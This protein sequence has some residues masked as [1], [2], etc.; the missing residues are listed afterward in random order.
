VPIYLGMNA[1][2][3]ASA[4]PASGPSLDN[5]RVLAGLIDLAIVGAGALAIA[6][7][8]GLLGGGGGEI[9]LPVVAVVT[10]W[11]LYY[12]FALE[13]GS[14]QTLGKK[15]MKIRVV[16]VDGSAAGM[17]DIAVR[18]V[19]R[20][21]DMQL[22]YLVGLVVMLLTGERRGRLGDLAAK[23]MLVSAD[24]PTIAAPPVDAVA[25]PGVALPSAGPV[26]GPPVAVAPAPAKTF[27]LPSYAPEP[28]AAAPDSA[29]PPDVASPS[30]RELAR[31]VVATTGSQGVA[32]PAREPVADAGPVVELEPSADVEPIAEAEPVPPVAEE[33]VA[34]E[35]PMGESELPEGPADEQQIVVKPVETVSAI[36]LVMGADEP[37]D[38]APG[39]ESPA[40]DSR[41]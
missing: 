3:H 41:A 26:G 13:S 1:T 33:P 16:R 21:V 31:D 38:E 22:M 23:T 28:A 20:V 32:E 5:R 35:P 8:A 27:T 2:A 25:L 34:E 4:L 30:L 6:L 17:G 19:L 14:G 18:T 24:T 7:A 11:A 39:A 40:D 36:D 15:L 10:A 9:G 29:P 37:A 12:P